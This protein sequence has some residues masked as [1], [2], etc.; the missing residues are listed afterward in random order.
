MSVLAEDTVFVG[1]ETV[2]GSKEFGGLNE[3]GGS[4]TAV[5]MEG[6]GITLNEDGSV[7][8]SVPE[9]PKPK[10]VPLLVGF[11]ALKYLGVF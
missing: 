11:I 5:S 1:G 6:S 3:M 2:G 9:P 10:I 7:T 8:L 4:G